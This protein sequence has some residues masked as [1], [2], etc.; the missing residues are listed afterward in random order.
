M[1]TP[2]LDIEILRDQAY[3]YGVDVQ[4]IENTLGLAFAQGM[5]G[6]IQTPLNVYWVI[7]E[8]LDRDLRKAG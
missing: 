5:T 1:N 2:F 8:L 7:L 6:Q 3:S 4:D